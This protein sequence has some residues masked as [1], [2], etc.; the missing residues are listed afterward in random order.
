MINKMLCVDD[1]SISLTIS[2]LLLKRTGFAD[3]IFTAIDG[4]DALIYFETHFAEN[5]NPQETAPNLILLDINMPVMNG[6]EFLDVYIAKYAE[7]L[8]NTKVVIL[9]STINPEDLLRAKEYAIV[10]QFVSKPLS[11]ENLTEL[12]EDD[13]VKKF[14]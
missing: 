12:K 14:F 1:D 2:K 8:P 10:A 11:V 7:K 3:Q 9:S 4:S 6:W 5:L 13:F